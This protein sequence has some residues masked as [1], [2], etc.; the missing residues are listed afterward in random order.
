M[1]GNDSF[2]KILNLEERI[3]YLQQEIRQSINQ[4]R[5]YSVTHDILRQLNRFKG[6]RWK[7]MNLR[8]V[9][10]TEHWRPRA[11]KRQ[12]VSESDSYNRNKKELTSS[13]WIQYSIVEQQTA[14]WNYQSGWTKRELVSERAK[15]RASDFTTSRSA[16]LPRAKSVERTPRSKRSAGC[17]ATMT[18]FCSDSLE[19]AFSDRS[20]SAEKVQACWRPLV[21]RDGE[22]SPRPQGQGQ[23]ADHSLL[24]TGP[25][26]NSP[27]CPW[28]RKTRFESGS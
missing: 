16:T 14:K 9:F 27:F 19:A 6:Q 22:L 3:S 4:Y 10:R 12:S 11:G 18:T 8:V 20:L 1:L 25:D 5:S 7:V 28:H 23:I 26:S 21:S 2:Y 13:H 15:A 17:A 24:R